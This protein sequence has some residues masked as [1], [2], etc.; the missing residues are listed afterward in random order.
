MRLANFKLVIESAQIANRYPNI[1]ITNADAL[2][3]GTTNI[4]A[5]VSILVVSFTL[6]GSYILYSFWNS[7]RK[8]G[9]NHMLRERWNKEITT[10]KPEIIL[11]VQTH[12]NMILGASFLATAMVT[13]AI[14]FVNLIMDPNGLQYLD[15]LAASSALTAVNDQDQPIFASQDKLYACMIIAFLAFFFM[16]QNIRLMVHAGYYIRA[17]CLYDNPEAKQIHEMYFQ[18][19]TELTL[20]AFS[21]FMAGLRVFYILIPV[22]LWVFGPIYL[23]VVSVVLTGLLIY[24]DMYSIPSFSFVHKNTSDVEQGERKDEHA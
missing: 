2:R 6:L 16:A 20:R 7:N 21:F 1:I 22:L 4:A 23:L 10:S 11:G 12:R 3:M 8:S 19:V 13:S 15:Q 9:R 14:W 17:I 5:E 18:D 24:S